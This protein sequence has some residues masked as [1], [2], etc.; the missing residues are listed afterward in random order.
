MDVQVARLAD[1]PVVMIRH[2]GPYE[3]LNREFDRLWEWVESRQ[4]PVQRTI[5]IYYDNP[6]FTETSNL[7]SAACVEVP[8]S[9]AFTDKGGLPLELGKITGGEYAITSFTGPYEALAPVWTAFTNHIER[10]MRRTIRDIPAF[11]VYV[12][13]AATTAPA[14]LITELYMP[15][16]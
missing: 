5:G 12:N 11:E 7:R 2:R 8:A 13:D 1:I 14:N 10:K 3:E 16:A 4:I 6:D 9:F 15:L